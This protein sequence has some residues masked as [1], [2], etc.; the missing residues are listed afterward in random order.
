M[1]LQILKTLKK[2][3]LINISNENY[4]EQ[5]ITTSYVNIEQN[6]LKYNI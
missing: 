4:I 3:Y 6:M 1:R 5:N 2:C